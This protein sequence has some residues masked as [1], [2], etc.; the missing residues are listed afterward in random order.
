MWI[1]IN[2]IIKSNIWVSIC[3]L[4]L[5]F[6]AEKILE[7]T[8]I[9]TAMFVFFATI[10]AY[11]F[12]LLVSFCRRHEHADKLWLNKNIKSI[13]FLMV[14]AFLLSIHFF[15]AFKPLTQ[16]AILFVA[17]LSVLYPFILRKIPFIKIF[18]IS[19]SWAISAVMFLVLE[20]N[21]PIS[22]N[23]ICTFSAIYLFVFAITI[24]FDIRDVDYD[25]NKIV[26]IPLFF[27]DRASKIIAIFS[28]FICVL[29]SFFQRIQ[30]YLSTKDLLALILLYIITAVFI[31]KSNKRNRKM[32][33]GFWV[34][35][36]S[37]LS[38]FLLV[39]SELIF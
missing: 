17:I 10:L 3:V 1:I 6:S 38:Y 26:T 20:N 21:I 13:L 36:L 15:L 16:L 37:L 2:F 12:Q 24:P 34:E 14:I 27:G 19:L 29:I 9:K 18:I 4:G 33:F 23:V 28:L 25:S 22:Q 11:N 32:Y 31:N 8:N 35:S 5:V 39:I 7:E 30:M